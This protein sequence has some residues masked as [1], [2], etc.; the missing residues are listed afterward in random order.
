MMIQIWTLR[1]FTV[2]RERPCR[3]RSQYFHR[4]SSLVMQI[5]KYVFIITLLQV[6]LIITKT[7]SIIT[8]Y[9]MF[10]KAKVTKP[11]IKVLIL[12]LLSLSGTGREVPQICPWLNCFF[13]YYLPFP[14]YYNFLLFLNSFLL[15]DIWRGKNK[16]VRVNRYVSAGTTQAYLDLDD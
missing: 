16:K 10:R 13:I 12:T 11:W 6:I 7:N 2:K 5:C 1:K 4:I 15:L 9:P 8:P 14:T 3:A